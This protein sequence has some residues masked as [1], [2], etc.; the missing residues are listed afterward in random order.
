[1]FYHFSETFSLIADHQRSSTW[2]M[3]KGRAG[4]H[5]KRHQ[6]RQQQQA[7]SDFDACV[8]L[9]KW[10]VLHSSRHDLADTLNLVPFHFPGNW[11]ID[12]IVWC[13]II[14]SW[15]NRQTAWIAILVVKVIV[16]VWL[17]KKNIK[18]IVLYIW[19][20]PDEPLNHLEPNFVQCCYILWW[21]FIWV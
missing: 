11:M 13:R 5:R 14:I 3:R 2:I 6:T 4:R 12:Y 19:G 18:K 7:P 16:R 8:D 17:L 1:M 20:I 21:S 10:M 15:S 9:R